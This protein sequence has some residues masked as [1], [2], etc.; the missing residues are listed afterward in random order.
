MS[1]QPRRRQALAYRIARQ[2]GARRGPPLTVSRLP[3]ADDFS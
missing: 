3:K 2:P 1:L